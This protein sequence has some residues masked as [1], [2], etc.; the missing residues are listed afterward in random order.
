VAEMFKIPDREDFERYRVV[1]CT[2][3]CST[4]IISRNI[5]PGFFSHIF[6]DEAGQAGE[7]EIWIPLGGLA[8]S[9]TS[10]IFCG[11]PKQLGPVCTLEL[12]P[13]VTKRFDSALVRYMNN[14]CY[15]EDGRLF[16]QL[17]RSYRCHGAILKSFSSL[18]YNNSLKSGIRFR[19]E[20]FQN[21]SGLPT[22]RFPILFVN[23]NGK[24]FMEKDSNSYA[25]NHEVTAV[26][27]YIRQILK[28]FSNLDLADIGVISPYRYQTQL[29][30]ERLGKER[31]H[32]SR[33]IIIDSVERFQGSERKVIIMTT[34]RTSGLGFV[35]CDLRLNTSISRA[36]NLLII[37]GN[38]DA[39]CG[40]PSWRKF[41][42]YCKQNKSLI[43]W[44]GKVPKF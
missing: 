19:P 31:I 29:L 25:N 24:Q 7:S 21:W 22:K 28:E 34:T 1:I 36:M 20:M 44:S 17:R 9:D 26:I 37:I 23:V 4:H 39:L 6:L 18:F 10:V 14:F 3:G 38:K 41:L 11:D 16:C 27:A 42:D 2:L 15:K 8:K 43:D 35:G 33:K 30:I 12:P 13:S 32:D 5:P 40:H